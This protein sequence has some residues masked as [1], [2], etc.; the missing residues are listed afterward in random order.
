MT[1]ILAH[2]TRVQQ[3]PAHRRTAVEASR[4]GDQPSETSEG[5]EA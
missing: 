1:D 2:D 4:A 3:P 5:T